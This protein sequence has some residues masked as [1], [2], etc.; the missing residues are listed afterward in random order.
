[1]QIGP[2]QVLEILNSNFPFKIVD[3]PL[4]NAVEMTAREAFVFSVVTGA[5]YLDNPL[6]PFTPKG[7]LK[8]FYNAFD[9][10]FVTGIFENVSLKNTPFLLSRAKPFLFNS[11]QKYVLPVSFQSE[12]EL[13]K[14]LEAY[15]DSVKAPEDYLILRIEASKT[16]SG[17][18]PFMEYLAT[19]YFRRIGYIV[20]TQIP[21][22]HSLGSPDF[23]G[24]G[25]AE[26]LNSLKE[27]NLLPRGFHIIELAMLRLGRASNSVDSGQQN[28][29]VVGEAKTG[30]KYMSKQLNKYLDTG[31]F[32]MGFEIHPAK[33]EP[34]EKW[35]G[36][37][38]LDSHLKIKFTPPVMKYPCKENYSREEYYQ[39]FN[40]YMKFYVIANLSNDELNCFYNDRRGMPIISQEDIVGFVHSLEMSD[41]LKF[42]VGL[43]V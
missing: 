17:M 24:Y 32:D 33:K 41:I 13:Q 9:Y 19:E 31:L 26:T 21:L 22:A 30:T 8:L 37:F 16:G 36:L 35:H 38:T 4:G 23:A 2:Q 5:G 43:G 34:S 11:Q 15:H 28:T 14:K 10:K 18:E 42:I 1:M 29:F 7:L 40:N 25:L 6:Y 12:I 27:L 3:T 20:E 39:W